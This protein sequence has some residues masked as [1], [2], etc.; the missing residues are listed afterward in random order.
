LWGLA[1]ATTSQAVRLL[2]AYLFLWV[3]WMGATRSENE[4]GTPVNTEEWC[5]ARFGLLLILMLV[6]YTQEIRLATTAYHLLS[7]CS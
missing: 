2:T 5:I 6:K 3:Q 7:A 4:D 1:A